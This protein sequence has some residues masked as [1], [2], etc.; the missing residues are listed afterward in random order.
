MKRIRLLELLL[1]LLPLVACDVLDFGR[2]TGRPGKGVDIPVEVPDTDPHPDTCVFVSA[3]RVTGGYDWR[4]DT[5]FGTSSCSVVLFRNYEVV[6]SLPADEDISPD[7]DM[8]HILDGHLYTEYASWNETSVRRDGKLVARWPGRERLCGL[9]AEGDVVYTLG[10]NRSGEGFSLRRNGVELFSRATGQVV[11]GLSDAS[12]PRTG[13]LCRDAGD[14]CFFFA[15]GPSHNRTLHLVRGDR[16]Q[17]LGSIPIGSNLVDAKIVDGRVYS[18]ALSSGTA[19]LCVDGLHGDAGNSPGL[20]WTDARIYP[21]GGGVALA[22]QYVLNGESGSGV[23]HRDGR[24]ERK[25]GPDCV[26]YGDGVSF[27]ALDVSR[28]SGIGKLFYFFHG[29][30]ATFFNNQLYAALSPRSAS[31]SAMVTFGA[32]LRRLDLDGYLTGIAV[33]VLP[34]EDP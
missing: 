25:G 34:A 1:L 22:G 33:S 20:S 10:Q 16:S 23:L 18:L 19:D 11:G 12:F 31:E 4:R 32:Q 3:V 2:R 6:L 21:E 8:H 15:D 5:A 24:L 7:P 28:T 9:W 26:I 13:A 27:T 14:L 29:G 30:C 17:Q